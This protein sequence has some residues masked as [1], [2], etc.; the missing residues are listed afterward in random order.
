MSDDKWTGKTI[1]MAL[2]DAAR[3]Y[4]DRVATVFDNG[5]VTY[6][7]LKHTADLIARGFLS[8]GI[9]KGDKVAVWMAG[10]SEWAFVYFALMRIG[11]IIVPVN[12]RYRPDEIEYV[13]NKSRAAVLIFKE[14]PNRDYLSLLTELCPRMG[15]SADALPNEKLPYLKRLVVSS[16]RNLPGWFPFDELKTLGA[17][18][19]ENSLAEA[20]SNVSADD[21]AMI[22]F[23]SGTTAMPK[24]AMLFQAAMLRGACCGSQALQLSESDRFFSP[25]PFFHVGGSIQVMLTPVVSGCTMIVQPY[26]HAGEA[27][28]IMERHRCNVLMGHQPHYIEYLNHPQ[29]KT[30]ALALEK[31]MIFASPQVNKRVHDEMGIKKLISPYGLTETHIGG[32]ACA[33]DDPLELRMTTVGKAMPGVEIAIR[34]P[35][36]EKFLP[37]G[38]SGEICFRGW[39]VT[40]GYYDDPEKTAEAIDG[41]GWFRT[42][43]LGVIGADGNLRL[44]GR[45]KDMIR[46]GGENVAAAEVEAVLL[47]HDAVKQAVAVGMADPRLAEVVAAF[48]ELKAGQANSEAELIAY[49]RQRLASFKVPR[50][51]IFVTDWPIT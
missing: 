15:D 7:R 27:L 28:E 13:L 48:V 10:Y 26:F 11:A 30:R 41:E 31:G 49:C 40:K 1:G 5:A 42:G 23:T 33:L 34:Q 16:Q 17:K 45:I 19:S 37:T 39:C 4:G 29:L 20:A 38:E 46:V 32:T 50:R 25:Q 21:I 8:L 18:V 9:G 51:I 24:G 44:I 47:K 14:E 12:T 43:D 2:D 36:A 6:M 3:K 35:G 22:Q